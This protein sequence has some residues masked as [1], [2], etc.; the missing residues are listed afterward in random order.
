MGGDA[1]AA[2]GPISAVLMARYD[3]YVN[4]D[5]PG[6]LLDVQADLLEGL[7]TRIVVPLSPADQAPAP[8]SRL[9]P[10]FEVRNVPHVLLTQF[11]AAV[12]LALLQDPVMSLLERDAE[13]TGALDMVFFGF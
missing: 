7:N 6:Y 11:M 5:G 12:P 1:R 4:P 10:V 8:A 3:V 13:I 9:N 2:A